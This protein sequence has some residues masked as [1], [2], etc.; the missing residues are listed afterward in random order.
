M[1]TIFSP[2]HRLHVSPGEFTFGTFVPAFEKPERADLVHARVLATKL[3]PVE[4][5]KPQPRDALLAAHDPSLVDFLE[6]AHPRWLEIGRTGAAYP[7]S[8]FTR[9]MRTDRVPTGIEAQLTF[10]CFD[11]ATPITA[12]TWAAVKS[13]AETALTAADLVAGGEKAAFALCR[14]PGHHAGYDHFGGYCFL[15]NAAIAVRRFTEKGAKRVAVLDID[16]HHGNGTQNIFY[17]DADV[18]VVNIHGDPNQEYP[19]L[20]GFADERGAGAGE[21]FNLNL[22]LPWGTEVP[23]W[24]G[25]LEAGLAAIADYAPDAVVVSLGVDTFIEDPIS[26][27]RLTSSDYLT[28]GTRIAK[29]GLPTLF[30]MEGGYAVE[31]VGINAVNVLLGF[32]GA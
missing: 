21:G 1:R 13:S 30:V 31:E 19:Y 10:Y 5:P 6:H 8:F 27:F 3:G 9:G 2:D 23:I 26:Q 7:S 28:V 12:T 17:R 20:L 14:P 29:L 15:N 11:G 32:E 25:A 4:A 24:M 18:F 16:Y 22:P